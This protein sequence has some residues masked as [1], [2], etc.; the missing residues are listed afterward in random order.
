MKTGP[1]ILATFFGIGFFPL[2][3]GTLTSLTVVIL[4]KF[5]LHNLSWPVYLLIFLGLF[6]IGVFVAAE[7]SSELGKKDP[8]K[9]VIDEAC[10]QLLVLFQLPTSWFLLLL[11]FFLFRLF[12]I[13]K[14]YPIRK[15]E[16]LKKGWGIM[17]DDILAAIYTIIVIR[18]YLLL[19]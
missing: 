7:Y 17:L 10:G 12:D 13:I 14:P 18:I 6:F 11:G 8:R 2:A 16:S 9:I 4:Y 3:P 1:R 15:I 19:R 5:F